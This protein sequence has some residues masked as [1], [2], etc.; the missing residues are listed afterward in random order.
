MKQ[1]DEKTIEELKNLI[2]PDNKW[3]FEK[4][5]GIAKPFTKKDLKTGDVVKTRNGNHYLV[6]KNVNA[7]CKANQ[8]FGLFSNNGYL[9]ADE[10]TDTLCIKG[11]GDN[12]FD[13]KEVYRMRG[14]MDSLCLGLRDRELI[15]SR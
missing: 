10:Y 9:V 8:E 5:M 7:G 13:I 12:E 4:L 15:W 3:K 11:I 6:I 2:A 1:L 14:G